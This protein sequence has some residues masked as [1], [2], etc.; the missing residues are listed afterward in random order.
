MID[1]IVPE[2]SNLKTE[3]HLFAAQRAQPSPLDGGRLAEV[4]SILANQG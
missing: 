3:S 1:R 2:T 4:W